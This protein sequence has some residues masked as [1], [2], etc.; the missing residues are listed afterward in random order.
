MPL[1]EPRVLSRAPM[2]PMRDDQDLR[3]VVSMHNMRAE[4]PREYLDNVYDTPSRRVG[5]YR[6]SSPMIEGRQR[7]AEEAGGYYD[8]PP[9][10]EVRFTRT[11]APAYREVYQEPE[12]QVHYEPLPP[13]PVERIVVD[14]Y[15]RRFRE[16]IQPAAERISIAPRA[17]SVRPV[18]H[19]AP[20]YDSYRDS[21]AGSVFADAPPAERQYAQ[22][23]P[24][25][26]PTYRHVAGTPRA[27]A[28]PLAPPRD[29]FEQPG[30]MRS[31]SVQVLDRPARQPMYMDE[32][33][34]FRDQ[35]RLG[36]IRPVGNQY[37]ELPREGIMRASSVRPPAREGTGFV[38]ERREYVPMEQPRYRVVEPE[39][40]Y[41]DSQGREVITQR[42]VQRY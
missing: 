42:A 31:A 14:Q 8:R 9:V 32:R 30:M 33:G 20:Q 16:I 34:D 3:R 23:M 27:S 38:D 7:P 25:P 1:S 28:A 12:P 18:E 13:A 40:R 29:Q 36:S 17:M 11:P 39:E 4:Q 19:E 2:R 10:Q 6:E 21:R 37:E 41:Y 22:E 5:S 26:R 24:P 15:G 35:V